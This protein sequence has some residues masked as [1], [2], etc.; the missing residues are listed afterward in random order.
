[1][2]QLVLEF[3]TAR[4]GAMDMLQELPQSIGLGVLNPRTDRVESPQ[5][6]VE[7]VQE[8]RRYVDAE[9][10]M[11]NPDCGFSTFAQRPMNSP[12]VASQKLRSLCEAR[13]ILRGNL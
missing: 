2:D 5:E 4:A 3:A 10:L 7:K 8:A 9:R 1:M 12:R 13:D 11:L 6:I